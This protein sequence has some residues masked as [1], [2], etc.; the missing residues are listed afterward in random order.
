[1]QLVFERQITIAG[2]T[3]SPGSTV[4]VADADAKDLIFR[5]VGQPA[6]IEAIVASSE[7]ISGP[8]TVTCIMPSKNRRAWLPR[9][10]NCFLE[11]TYQKKELFIL[12]NGES[13]ADLLPKDGRIRYARLPGNQTTG[14]LRNFCCRLSRAEFI[15]HWDDDDWS[16]RDRLAE[17]ISAIEGYHVTGYN[18]ILFHGPKGVHRWDGGRGHA[19]GT[20]LLYRREWWEKNQFPAQRI[21]ED[22]DFIRRAMGVMHYSDGSNRIVASIHAENTSPR[23][24]NSDGYKPARV[25]DLPEGYICQSGS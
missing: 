3:Y 19:C 18:S 8:G 25:E 13:I 23:P 12:D 10:I 14:Q 7:G 22:N 5:G 11:Q 16:H 21:G 1:M 2:V 17:Q 20:S 15:A 4:D 9:A 24:L 6:R